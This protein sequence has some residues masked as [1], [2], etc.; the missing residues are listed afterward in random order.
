MKNS[1]LTKI[2]TFIVAVAL[3][4]GIAFAFNAAA[5][6]ETATDSDLTIAGKN[7]VYND[8][9]SIRYAV[10][11]S[12][13]SANAKL[14]IES[15]DVSGSVG[16][17]ETI[18]TDK[19]TG[20]EDTYYI[21]EV[22]GIPAS[23]VC[24]EIVVHIEDGGKVGPELKY[25]L[26]EYF[27]ERLYADGVVNATDGKELYQKKLYL[28]YLEYA[29]NAQDLFNNFEQGLNET[30]VTDRFYLNIDGGAVSGFAA[31]VYEPNS[32]VTITPTDDTTK[33]WKLTEYS[34]VDGVLTT[35]TRTVSVGAEIELAAHT[36][37]APGSASAGNYY[38]VYGGYNYEGATSISALGG[39]VYPENGEGYVILDNKAK[40]TTKNRAWLSIVNDSGN[41]VVEHL[42]MSAGP[43]SRNAIRSF[44]ASSTNEAEGNCLV[45]ETKIKVIAANSVVYQGYYSASDGSWMMN[46]TAA[47]DAVHFADIG[48]LYVDSEDGGENLHFHVGFKGDAYSMYGSKQINLSEWH[49]ITMMYYSNGIVVYYVDGEKFIEKTV[50]G[51][52]DGDFSTYVNAVGMYMREAATNSAVYFDDTFV[53]VIKKDY[54]AGE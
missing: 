24:K 34:F 23:A 28:S 40:D 26:A 46:F 43:K 51:A 2:F 20:T 9:L 38:D 5:E 47:K 49:T 10:S 29:A 1:K 16:Y 33:V 44:F 32:K 17:F 15:E 50:S 8:T 37:V 25:S 6:T 22:T 35:Q 41:T 4:L 53:G 39:Q 13:I 42:T 18:T 30:L 31:G 54:V 12:K 19:I 45:F 11:T 48:S 14:F 27:F 3:M 36:L 21:F 52:I 7:I